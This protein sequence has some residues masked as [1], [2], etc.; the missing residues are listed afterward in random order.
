MI[1][2]TAAAAALQQESPVAGMTLHQLLYYAQ[3]TALVQRG[4]PLFPEA[5]Q[6]W[7]HGP[8]SRDLR[9]GRPDHTP[10]P[11]EDR[12]LLRATWATYGH[13]SA[14]QLGDLSRDDAP[15]RDTRGVLP[16]A[17]PCDRVI[18]QEAMLTFYLGRELVQDTG[19]R[20]AHA[21]PTDAQWARAKARLVIARQ[22]RLGALGGED[23]RA[24]IGRQVVA[25]QRLE[26]LTVLCPTV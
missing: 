11:L 6:A 16:P 8:V 26:G 19:G 24:F 1:S 23:R 2:I 18:A 17:A 14:A 3:A 22:A 5:F 20:W 9:N 10:V 21:A 13:L 12:D 25:T 4:V 7:R 15:W